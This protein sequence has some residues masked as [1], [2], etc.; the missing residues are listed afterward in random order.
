M[1]FN[2]MQRKLCHLR[3]NNFVSISKTFMRQTKSSKWSLKS[4]GNI[5]E[6]SEVVTSK[7]S[8]KCLIKPFIFTV[9]FS[10]CSFVA[11][12]VWQYEEMRIYAQNMFGS[13]SHPYRPRS[14]EYKRSEFRRQINAWWNAQSEGEKVAM[15]ILGINLC[16]FLFWRIPVLQ[17]FMMKYFCASPALR[18][19]CLP[20]FL[21]TFSHYSFFHLAMNM[22]VL[23]S[24]SN[25]AVGFFGK[26]Q[27]VAM[28]CSAGVISSFASYAF[29]VASGRLVTSLGASGALMAI[30]SS[31]C[32]QFPEIPLQIVFL[33][34]FTFTASNAIKAI[35]ALDF[36]GLVAKWRLFDHAAHLGGAIYG[37]LYLNYGTK[38]I[39]NNR[40]PIFSFYHKL[41]E[42]K[43]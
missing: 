37:I 42:K 1:L 35:M 28:Y 6:V 14:P 3:C 23:Y 31:I 17:P 4:D 34:F 32:F 43:E 12:T 8:P 15:A 20:M 27:F 40:E 2:V 21:S 18:G 13:H 22:Y 38:Y 19:S 11:C 36:V 10:G 30:L 25:G 26:E 16:V 29:K 5:N 41:R 33:P 9:T 24:F 7:L 39:W